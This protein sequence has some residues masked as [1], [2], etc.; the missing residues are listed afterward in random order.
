MDTLSL[1]NAAMT[2]VSDLL[3]PASHKKMSSDFKNFVSFVCFEPDKES[4]VESDQDK[5]KGTIKRVICHDNAIVFIA[6]LFLAAIGTQ[7]YCFNTFKTSQTIIDL[8]VWKW[9]SAIPGRNDME[10]LIKCTPAILVCS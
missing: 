4:K 1:F 10:R 6:F 2:S 8:P 3:K 9:Y 5:R 7:N